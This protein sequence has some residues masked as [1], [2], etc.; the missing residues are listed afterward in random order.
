MPI[1][2][3]F[4]GISIR[5]YFQQAEHNP[6]HIHAIYGKETVVV[7][8]A[9]GEVLDG[10]LPHKELSAVREW[11]AANRDEL[12]QIWKTQQFKKLPPLQ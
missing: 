3:K 5:M 4:N 11:V 7:K 8:I 6:P 10:N 1:L 12:L 2:S 9:T